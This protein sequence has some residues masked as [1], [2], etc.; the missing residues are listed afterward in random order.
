MRRSSDSDKT[1]K[2]EMVKIP[3]SFNYLYNWLYDNSDSEEVFHKQ[4]AC[5][6]GFGKTYNTFL[7]YIDNDL[8]IRRLQPKVIY[9][10]AN[11]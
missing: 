2:N 4:R 5:R 8:N 9:R 6:E 7:N 11:I 10:S 3:R 1:S